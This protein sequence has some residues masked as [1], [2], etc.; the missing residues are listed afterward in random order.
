MSSLSYYNPPGAA[1]KHSELGHYS[2]AVDLGNG[3]VKCAGQGGWD[4]D[5]GDLDSNDSDKQ[6]QLAI[7]NVDRVLRES[8]L[9][10]WEDVYLLRSYH[11]DI[12]TSWE[13]TVRALKERI[14]SHRPVC[15][16]LLKS[17]LEQ[18]SDFAPNCTKLH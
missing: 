4:P 9:R 1:Q 15:F 13:P 14:P 10:G 8:G 5:T 2:Q 16:S 17:L 12:R 7:E 11:V 18:D 3:L 6:V